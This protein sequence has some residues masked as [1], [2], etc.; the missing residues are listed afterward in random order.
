MI[1][2]DN[3]LL[4]KMYYYLILTRKVD[5]K[6]CGLYDAEELPEKP[7][8]AIGQEATAVGA[9][10]AIGEDDYVMPSLRTRGAFLTKGLT[11]TELLIEM[12]R[13]EGSKSN[14]RWTAHHMGDPEKKI[15]LSSALI[16]SS[17]LVG[18]GAALANKINK[19]KNVS[20]VF[21]GDGASSRGDIHAALNFAAV[22]NLPVVFICEN[23][24][25]AV[26][27][28]L[29]KQTKN[30][31]IADR[32]IGYDIP[33]EKVDGQDIIEVYLATQ[34][35]V[36]RA[37]RNL[38]PSLIECKTYHFR[39][40]S[41]SHHPDDNRPE[42]ELKEWRSRCPVEIF[43]QYLLENKVSEKSIKDIENKVDKKIMTA[44]EKV[45]QLPEVDPTEDELKRYVYIE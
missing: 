4:K 42:D 6:I 39:G 36:H 30:P 5:E 37:R 13:K 18:T 19:N 34:R 2:L 43:K 25:W 10:L 1:E 11:V 15:L 8:S 33:G 14:G 17:V 27:T 3:N 38:G 21:F 12:Y 16:G 40:H 32:A 22:Q 20:L 45:K 24:K 26:S 7:L 9:T 41:E 35:A 31:D 23:N 44:L 29:N 28:D